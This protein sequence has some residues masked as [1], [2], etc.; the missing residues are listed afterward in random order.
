MI[1]LFI[2]EVLTLAAAS[3]FAPAVT[4]GTRTSTLPEGA[5]FSVPAGSAGFSTGSVTWDGLEGP[6]LPPLSGRVT[7]TVQ[8]AT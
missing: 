8:M 3:P 7:V 1:A 2:C 4:G 5:G 6:L